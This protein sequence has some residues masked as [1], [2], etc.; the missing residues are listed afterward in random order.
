[1][2]SQWLISSYGHYNRNSCAYPDVA[3]DDAFFAQVEDGRQV[4]GSGTSA[5][6]PLFASLVHRINIERKRAS[7]TSV[8]FVESIV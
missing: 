2:S 4:I 7:K 6:A 5:S 3:V 8:G 1:M